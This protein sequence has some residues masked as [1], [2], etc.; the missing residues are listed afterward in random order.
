MSPWTSITVDD[1]S[2]SKTKTMQYKIY[3]PTNLTNSSTN[4]VPAVIWADEQTSPNA[5]AN[6]ESLA[7]ANRF[8]LV[9]YQPGTYQFTRVTATLFFDPLTVPWQPI[10]IPNC[11]ASGAGPCDDKPGMIALLNS[12]VP[13]Q[14]I[15]RK[16]IFMTGASKGGDFTVELMC[17]PATNVFF[18]G[19]GIVSAALWSAASVEDATKNTCRSFNRDSSVMFIAGD[20]DTFPPYNGKGQEG[21]YQ[22]SQQAG[23][24]YLASSYGCK[25]GP[26]TSTFGAA[27]S[28]RQDHYKL[29]ARRF[30]SIDLITVP[31]GGHAY[32]VDGVQGLNSE[33][34]I[35]NFWAAH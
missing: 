7:V 11:G 2:G 15:D 24:S 23:V 34:T 32:N 13:A 6:W 31:G 9:V 30:R 35:W 19:F 12:V 5:I 25:A 26:V 14:H 20:A 1:G 16:K 28:L 22:W 18:R 4:E 21:H 33:A 29:C 10:P 8:V 3:R 27:G 17:S